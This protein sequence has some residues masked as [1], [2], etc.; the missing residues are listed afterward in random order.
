MTF[1]INLQK[2]ELRRGTQWFAVW[3]TSHDAGQFFFSACVRPLI[4]LLLACWPLLAGYPF[5]AACFAGAG[6]VVFLC[7][8][9]LERMRTGRAF[10]RQ[11]KAFGPPPVI[12]TTVELGE[13]CITTHSEYADRTLPYD[14]VRAVHWAKADLYLYIAGVLMVIPYQ[15]VPGGRAAL[16]R[17]LTAKLGVTGKG[18]TRA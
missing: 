3:M 11:E 10:D 1:K 9:M 14:A 2:Q 8:P 17:H 15:D 4:I 6:V 5:E 16:A 13:T 12:E 7:W 18:V